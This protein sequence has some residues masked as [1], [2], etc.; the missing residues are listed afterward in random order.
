MKTETEKWL[1]I[2]IAAERFGYAHKESLS[3]RLR[4]LRKRGKVRD[5]GRPPVQYR[6]SDPKADAEITIMWPNPKTALL[7]NDGPSSLLQSSR[8][9]PTKSQPK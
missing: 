3:R 7:R 8:G 4:Q 9:R 2:D 5:T 6:V 1:P